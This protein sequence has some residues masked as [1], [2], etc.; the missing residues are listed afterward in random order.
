MQC[1]RINYRNEMLPSARGRY[2]EICALKMEVICC[3]ETM[4]SSYQV[5][6]CYNQQGDS[7]LFIAVKATKLAPSYSGLFQATALS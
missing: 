4:K 5:T 2:H 7:M 6:R 1:D 3:S